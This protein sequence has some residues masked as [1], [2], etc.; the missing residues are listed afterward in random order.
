MC[1]LVVDLPW[2][3]R[4]VSVLLT[5]GVLGSCLLWETNADADKNRTA[6]AGRIHLCVFMGCPFLM[7]ESFSI[8][9]DPE[10]IYF[11]F[12]SQTVRFRF[13]TCRRRNPSGKPESFARDTGV[14]NPAAAIPR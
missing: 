4:T 1:L 9:L 8:R 10:W 12:E 5:D 3:V 7:V 2:S 6:T 14:L 13:F 11:L